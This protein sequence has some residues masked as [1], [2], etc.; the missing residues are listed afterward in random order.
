[1]LQ[2]SIT[3]VPLK[4]CMLGLSSSKG[5]AK[6]PTDSTIKAQLF[7]IRDFVVGTSTATIANVTVDGTSVKVVA[8]ISLPR[9][10]KYGAFLDVINVGFLI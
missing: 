10:F 1:M 2:Q 8:T 6:Y 5:V 7:V 4:S 3:Y 9:K